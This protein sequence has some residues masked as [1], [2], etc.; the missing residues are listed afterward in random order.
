MKNIAWFYE[1]ETRIHIRLNDEFA[2]EL[3]KNKV[4]H[5]AMHYDDLSKY[6]SITFA[7]NIT[8]EMLDKVLN[9]NKA[10]EA[11]YLKNSRV[12]LSEYNGSVNFKLSDKLCENCNKI[13]EK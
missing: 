6:A 10:I 8:K 11:V 7:P 12:Q 2:K 3:D 1:K 9:D 13:K 4:Y 5:I